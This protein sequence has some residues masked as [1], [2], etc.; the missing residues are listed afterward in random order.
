MRMVCPGAGT[1]WCMAVHAGEARSAHQSMI[2]F[3]ASTLHTLD[4]VPPS[5]QPSRRLG[6]TARRARPMSCRCVGGREDICEGPK[7][8]TPWFSELMGVLAAMAEF[9]CTRPKTN[10]AASPSHTPGRRHLPFQVQRD[11]GEE[12]VRSL[13]GFSSTV[14][15][16]VSVLANGQHATA[17]SCCTRRA[18]ATDTVPVD[19]H[20][21]GSIKLSFQVCAP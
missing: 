2:F 19:L 6:S 8:S 21:V 17:W 18:L 20:Q 15:A 13:A 12:E 10:T 14:Y 7:C 1:M 11:G 4:L 3:R 16:E 9:L 5:P